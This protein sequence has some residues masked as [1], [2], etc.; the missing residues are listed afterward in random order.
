MAPAIWQDV[1]KVYTMVR[2]RFG[3]S[4]TG[5]FIDFG[6]GNPQARTVEGYRR[7]L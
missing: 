2:G 6:E 4:V 5:V 1:F 3:E 7:V